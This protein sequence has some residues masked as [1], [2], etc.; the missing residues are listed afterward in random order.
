MPSGVGSRLKDQ[1]E[2]ESPVHH[3]NRARFYATPKAGKLRTA[4]NAIYI[5]IRPLLPILR[6]SFGLNPVQIEIVNVKYF[7]HYHD[8]D[9]SQE[10]GKDISQSSRE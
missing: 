4:K 10:R 9:I 8:K 5:N 3:L 6:R 2:G 7:S 1:A